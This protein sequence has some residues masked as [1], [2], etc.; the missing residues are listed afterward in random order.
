M[1]RLQV[2]TWSLLLCS[3]WGATQHLHGQPTTRPV[4]DTSQFSP[5]QPPAVYPPD[6]CSPCVDLLTTVQHCAAPRALTLYAQARTCRQIR[7]H[8]ICRWLVVW[9]PAVL[10]RV[11]SSCCQELCRSLITCH[12]GHLSLVSLVTSNNSMMLSQ[13]LDHHQHHLLQRVKLNWTLR[14]GLQTWTSQCW[15]VQAVP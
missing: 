10:T 11:S 7:D 5:D 13:A 6:L 15:S 8:H 12:T 4:P 3:R 14:L 1:A 9:P 2:S